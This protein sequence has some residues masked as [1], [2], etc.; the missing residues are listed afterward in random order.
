MS[1]SA[2]E[3]RARI[4]WLF[5]TICLLIE[6]ILSTLQMVGRPGIEPEPAVY[7]TAVQN[8]LDHLPIFYFSAAPGIRTRTPTKERLILSEVRLPFRQSSVA[9]RT[10]YGA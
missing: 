7:Q 3:F 8:Q 6:S 1:K 5:R 2:V 4:S 9:F 10:G